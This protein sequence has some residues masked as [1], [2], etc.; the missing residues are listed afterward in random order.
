MVSK[1]S[2]DDSRAVDL[3]LDR[4]SAASQPAPGGVYMAPQVQP[5]R[6]QAV[7]KILGLLSA[8]EAA[9]PPADL[10]ARTMRRIEENIG[11]A[12]AAGIAQQIAAQQPM[13]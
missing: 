5:Q 8:Y 13:I 7:E 2:D 9:E 1:L 4:S 11:V 6:A 10:V 12:P 3:V